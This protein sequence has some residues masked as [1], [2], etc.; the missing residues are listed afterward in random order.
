MT[1][2]EALVSVSYTALKANGRW[3]TTGIDDLLRRDIRVTVEDAVRLF[4]SDGTPEQL[5]EMAIRELE[6]RAEREAA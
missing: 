6:R 5:I 4:R 3:A 1:T 2:F